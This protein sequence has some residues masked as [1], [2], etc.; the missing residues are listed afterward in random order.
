MSPEERQRLFDTRL[1][2]LTD[3]Q[4]KGLDPIVKNAV[5]CGICGSPADRYI[6]TFECQT[7]PSHVGDL[8][9]GI[10][11]DLTYPKA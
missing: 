5:S 1:A 11:S 2:P 9:V 3:R 8:M 7:N 6:H 10:F 4:L